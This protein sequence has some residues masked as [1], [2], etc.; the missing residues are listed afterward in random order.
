MLAGK[1]T[2]PTDKPQTAAPPISSILSPIKLDPLTVADDHAFLDRVAAQINLPDYIPP[3]L[4]Q[5]YSS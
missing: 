3:G 4:R 2:G 5:L 1:E